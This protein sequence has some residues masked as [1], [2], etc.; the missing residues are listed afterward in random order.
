MSSTLSSSRRQQMIQRQ[1]RRGRRLQLEHLDDRL[2]LAADVLVTTTL[3][4]TE[5]VLREFTPGGA[6]VRTALLPVVAGGHEPGRDLIYDPS[7]KVHAYVGTFDPA[8]S[9]YTLDGGGWTQR[10]HPGW[11][12]YNTTSNGGIGQW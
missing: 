4:S 12:T 2:A 10:T 11:S 8:L 7:G 9:S 3:A 6:L 1:R 5:H